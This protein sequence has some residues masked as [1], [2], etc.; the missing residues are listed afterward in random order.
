LDAK[1]LADAKMIE[2]AYSGREPAQLQ[3]GCTLPLNCQIKFWLLQ[4]RL[5]K[6]VSSDPLPASRH[7]PLVE[8]FVL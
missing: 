5:R 8:G 2:K 3:A 7:F 6:R 4:L 1:P